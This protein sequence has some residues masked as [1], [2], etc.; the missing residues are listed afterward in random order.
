MNRTTTFV[1]LLLVAALAIFFFRK[2]ESPPPSTNPPILEGFHP[3]AVSEV[4][5]E[6]L[7]RGV[8]ASFRRVPGGWEMTLPI[9]YPAEA[10]M[11]EALL[12]PLE[13]NTCSRIADLQLRPDLSLQAY[14]LEKP[15]AVIRVVQGG[16]NREIRIGAETLSAD[17]VFVIAEGH[18]LQTSRNLLNATQRNL[19]ELR[20]KAVFRIPFESVRAF[21]VWRGGESMRFRNEEGLWQMESPWKE[22]ADSAQVNAFLA[23]LA[24]IRAEKF[25][26]DHPGAD[27]SY[28]LDPPMYRVILRDGKHEEEL[29]IG[30]AP[31]G[32]FV[33]RRT[34]FPFVWVVSEEFE[35]FFHQS[36]SEFRNRTFFSA[37]RDQIEELRLQTQAG[38]MALVFRDGV[39]RMASPREY[40]LHRVAVED[41]LDAM[42]RL[43]VSE[44][45]ES[46]SR[47]LAELGLEVPQLSV[48][49]K[50][51]RQAPVRVFFGHREGATKRWARRDGTDTAL[52]VEE[53]AVP[54][55]T[56]SFLDYI[57][58]VLLAFDEPNLK[59]V[60]LV[61]R[62]ASG[63][64][65]R[66]WVKDAAGR[67]RPWGAEGALAEKEDAAFVASLDRFLF[68][69]GRKALFEIRDALLFGSPEMEIRYFQASA[70]SGATPEFVAPLVKNGEGVWITRGR[71]PVAFDLDP[72]IVALLE[73][74]LQE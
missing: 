57:D 10:A 2:K 3:Q 54:F 69:K 24:G 23:A 31:S 71:E 26:D 74:L 30:R 47:S 73:S 45:P 38:E 27:A 25:F 52:L 37:Y 35:R 44:F 8:R 36:A 64:M 29:R 21:E 33:A 18:L 19:E 15:R 68:W 63:E 9:V 51:A 12:S 60:D 5:F 17:Q 72:K 50:A 20:N 66:S 65:R 40:R 59:R 16:K 41:L 39:W 67:W 55:L 14:G 32:D 53:S 49:L 34:N 11:V 7:D 42:Q 62:N 13:H 70:E 4:F 61:R 28:G 43:V 22:P 6:S 48:Q 58:P 1:L 56:T 46:Q